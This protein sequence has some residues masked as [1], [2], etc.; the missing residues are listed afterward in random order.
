MI[1]SGVLGVEQGV[2]PCRVWCGRREKKR[3]GRAGARVNCR[4]FFA[5]V[6]FAPRAPSLAPRAHALLPCPILCLGKYRCWSTVTRPNNPYRCVR[7]WARRLGLHTCALKKNAPCRRRRIPRLFET[8]PPRP[9]AHTALAPPLHPAPHPQD[10]PGLPLLPGPWA[11]V[12]REPTPALKR[13]THIKK[14]GAPADGRRRDGRPDCRLAPRQG[15]CRRD[16]CQ[17]VAG[18]PQPAP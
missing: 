17:P 2:C 9:R 7:A 5:T 12:T 4:V 18:R 13:N 11:C 16:R 15:R 3:G 14:H 1:V 6:S 10:D 8:P